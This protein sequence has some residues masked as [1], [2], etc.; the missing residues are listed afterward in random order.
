M[1]LEY[2]TSGKLKS[3]SIVASQKGTTIVVEALFNN[4]P[5]RRRELEK[6]IKREYSRAL[7]VLNSYACVS[8]GVRFVVS[9]ILQNGRK[10]VGFS[11]NSN[12]KT[13]DNIA[14]VFGAKTLSALVPLDL[15]FDL[16]PTSSIS[17]GQMSSRDGE[18]RTV[19]IIGHISRPSFGEG[20]QTPDRQMFFVNSRPCGLPQIAKAFNEVYKSYNV[21]QSPFVFADIRIDTSGLFYSVF[22]IHTDD[23]QMRMTLMSLR[24]RGQSC[25]MIKTHSS[26]ISRYM[27][28]C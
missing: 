16:E 28:I 6:N 9:N 8:T 7:G 15:K 20:R 18:T 19:R 26:R 3:T 11:T 12:L 21:S 24:I 25:S 22:G 10:T 14:N 17:Y 5:V 27:I 13:R 2:E 23:E 1:K 4:L